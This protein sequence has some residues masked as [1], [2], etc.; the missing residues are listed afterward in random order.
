ME[1]KELL[2]KVKAEGRSVLTE[3]ESKLVMREVGVPVVETRVARSRDAAMAAARELGFPVVAKILSQDITHKSES[4]GVE[5][6]LKNQRDVGAAY[7]RITEAARR[8]APTARIE[9]ITVQPMAAP[10]IEVIVGGL[11][12]PQFGPVLM[13][14]LGGIMVEVF[15]DVTFRI[16]PIN[17][18]DASQ[19][20]RQLKGYPVLAGTRGRPPADVSRLEETLMTL[21]G[22]MEEHPEVAEFD[23]NPLFVY[24]Q[25][26]LAVDA[27]IVL[28]ME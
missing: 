27:R 22:F 10:G 17:R 3:V 19:M 18:R 6:G 4:G 11:T 5:L 28:S 9:G 16:V 1:I 2:K 24:S 23:L 8:A 25:G 26:L 15:K 14:G 13:V 20:V 12:D 21:S 7:N